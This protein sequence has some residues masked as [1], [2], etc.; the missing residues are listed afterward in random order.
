MLEPLTVQAFLATATQKIQNF[1]TTDITHA[2]LIKTDVLRRKENTEEEGREG[3]DFKSVV[4]GQRGPEPAQK[5]DH[6]P[7]TGKTRK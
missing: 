1:T 4:E 7:I 3:A 5:C 6:F 2:N